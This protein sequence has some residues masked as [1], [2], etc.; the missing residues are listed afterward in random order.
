MFPHSIGIMYPSIYPWFLCIPLLY[1]VYLCVLHSKIDC[2]IPLY[3]RR[4][5][6]WRGVNFCHYGCSKISDF[7]FK[8]MLFFCIILIAF[9]C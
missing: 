8:Y 1:P 5:H 6:D 4:P 9:I 3:K 7:T 2:L